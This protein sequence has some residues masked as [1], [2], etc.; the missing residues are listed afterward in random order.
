MLA[1]SSWSMFRSLHTFC[2][3]MNVEIIYFLAEPKDN[4]LFCLY[5]SMLL[6]LAN[7]R[8]TMIFYKF[9]NAYGWWSFVHWENWIS[10]SSI[11]C[12]FCFL[13]FLL[14]WQKLFAFLG[15]NWVISD[16][17]VLCSFGSVLCD[18]A[19]KESKK[20]SILHWISFLWTGWFFLVFFFFPCANKLFYG[21]LLL[22]HPYSTFFSGWLVWSCFLHVGPLSECRLKIELD[23]ILTRKG[24]GPRWH[25]WTRNLLSLASLMG[26]LR[27][28]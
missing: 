3:K 20:I 8:R 6:V 24:F 19:W 14:L 28:I 12:L 5:I 26:K 13:F 17:I 16:I 27:G 4:L 18:L 10:Y 25:R 21:T 7:G 11:A 1:L 2:M 22:K 9:S 23:I 15:I